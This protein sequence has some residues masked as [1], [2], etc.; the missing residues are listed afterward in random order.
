[1][2][3]PTAQRHEADVGGARDHVQDR[4]AALVAGG[5]VQEHQLVGAGGVVGGGL[6]DRI[7]GVAQVRGT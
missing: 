1:M 3:P 7:A 5:D 2:P 4:A 6:L